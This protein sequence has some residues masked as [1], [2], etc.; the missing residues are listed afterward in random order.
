MNR[1]LVWTC[2][3]LAV[4]S[5]AARANAV[6]VLYTLEGDSGTGPAATVTDKLIADGSHNGAVQSSSP[7]HI[8][9]D[10]SPA[11]AAFGSSSL[12]FP[13]PHV[14]STLT[15]VD[16]PGTSSLGTEFTV[17]V[18]IKE[19]GHDFTRLFS[20]YDG[21]NASTALALTIDPMDPPAH[22]YNV[23]GSIKNTRVNR[24]VTGGFDDG[25]YHHVAMTYKDVAGTG[26]ASVFFDGAQLGITETT[27]VGGAVNLEHDVR[28]GEDYPGT[29]IANE[30]VE[31][32]ADD[33]L[34]FD[35][36]LSEG[37]MKLLASQGAVGFLQIPEP[38]TGGVFLVLVLVGWAGLARRRRR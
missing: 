25:L 2:A 19:I 22:T 4:F 33:I 10:T 34:I 16:I 3:T 38:S 17:A 11:N 12:A 30:N 21:T 15:V 7:E 35:R 23:F 20:T 26:Y 28:F 29:G 18:Q 14:S 31:G 27:A 24:T 6:Q 9:V 8:S 37:E 1:L 5:L 32:W 36:A 13:A